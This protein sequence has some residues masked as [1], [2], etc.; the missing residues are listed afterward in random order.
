MPL[1]WQ[2]GGAFW[3]WYMALCAVLV[4]WGALSGVP[5]AWLAPMILLGGLVGGRVIIAGLTPQV[6]EFAFCALW[7]CVALT[8]VS[9]KAWVPALCCGLSAWAYVSLWPLGF[10]IEHLGFLPVVADIAFLAGVGFVGLGIGLSVA[11]GGADRVGAL[12]GVL[13]RG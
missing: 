10:R 4:L 9:V 13:P 11:A 1:P 3:P 6:H 7:L 12:V 5:R 2:E 8:L